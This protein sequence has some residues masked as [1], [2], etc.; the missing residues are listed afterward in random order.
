MT[1]A[2]TELLSE[3]DWLLLD[4]ASHLDVHPT[5]LAWLGLEAD[6]RGLPGAAWSL[7]E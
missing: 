4:G 3:R 2:L 7:A 5:A 6:A 1:N